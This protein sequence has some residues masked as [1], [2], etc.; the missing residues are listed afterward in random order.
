MIGATSGADNC[1]R[2]LEM[3]YA[4]AIDRKTEDIAARVKEITGGAG[5]PVVYDSIGNRASS[6]T[7]NAYGK[8][9]KE[10]I[11]G[12]DSLRRAAVQ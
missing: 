11:G 10:G 6:W 3:G 1:A 8:S 12:S 5:V 7:V 9:Q 2:A 4:H